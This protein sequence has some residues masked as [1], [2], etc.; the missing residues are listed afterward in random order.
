MLSLK[1]SFMCSKDR[2]NLSIFTVALFIVCQMTQCIVLTVQCFYLWRSK[3][4]TKMLQGSP[5]EPIII[6]NIILHQIDESLKEE[7]M[8][9]SKSVKTLD[10]VF[11]LIGKQGISY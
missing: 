6:P 3:G 2:V 5:E 7:Q 11:Y 4:E 9:Y 8:K 1:L 10:R